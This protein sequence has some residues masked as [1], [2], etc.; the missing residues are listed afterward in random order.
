[1]LARKKFNQGFTLIEVV[2]SIVVI[3][4][5]GVVAGRGFLEIIAGYKMTKETAAVTQRAQITMA[6]IKKELATL[7][8]ISCGS[9]KMIT[10]K[11]KR[12]TAES[13]D[14]STIYKTTDNKIQLKTGSTC[15]TCSTCSDGDT[16]VENVSEFSLSYCKDGATNCSTSFPVSGFTAATVVSV[17]VVLKLKGYEDTPIAVAD[18]DIV[19][20]GLATGG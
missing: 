16:L 19:I 15:T 4:I 17:K 10:Y 5:I 1:M 6:R 14:T 11:I 9:D 3:A 20:L 8:S 2:V 18:P 7:T 12:S 13:E